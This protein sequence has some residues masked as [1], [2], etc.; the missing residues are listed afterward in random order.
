MVKAGTNIRRTAGKMQLGWKTRS[1]PLTQ[2]VVR[3]VPCPL[4]V[5][6]ERPA[7]I[8][9]VA[10]WLIK[11][12]PPAVVRHVPGAHLPQAHARVA[13]Q[14]SAGGPSRPSE[15]PRRGPP[16]GWPCG[17]TRT[18]RL[19]RA[20]KALRG[21]GVVRGNPALRRSELPWRAGG[22]LAHCGRINVPRSIGHREERD[23]SSRVRLVACGHRGGRARFPF[24]CL[25]T[26]SCGRRG[27]R[28]P[29]PKGAG[30]ARRAAW[31]SRRHAQWASRHGQSHWRLPRLRSWRGVWCMR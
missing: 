3:T 24:R 26:A 2:E 6:M 29:R 11:E 19:F 17:T 18:R 22:R 30:R 20:S 9:T 21:R 13:W 25:G 10:E 15:A 31:A 1:N 16:H 14:A 8:I 5:H 12:H 4:H 28:A 7:E 27:R 23:R